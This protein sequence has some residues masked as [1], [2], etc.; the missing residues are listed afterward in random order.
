MNFI[1]GTVEREARKEASRFNVAFSLNPSRA[2]A[3]H[4]GHTLHKLLPAATCPPLGHT[5]SPRSCS[6]CSAPGP[7]SPPGT[8]PTLHL[9]QDDKVIFSVCPPVDFFLV[10]VGGGK[11]HRWAAEADLGSLGFLP[12]AGGLECPQ[13]WL[14]PARTCHSH[15]PAAGASCWPPRS[16]E[17]QQPNV[18]NAEPHR[19]LPKGPFLF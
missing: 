1:F 5:A 13:L 15:K 6:L 14:S 17:V 9:L 19:T 10:P 12:T 3:Q 18:E 7:H 11:K 16:I 8:T 4:S 2:R